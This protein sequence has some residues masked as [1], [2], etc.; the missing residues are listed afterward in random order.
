MLGFERIVKRIES[1]F[2]YWGLVDPIL[3]DDNRR[4]VALSENGEP[5]V[6]RKGKWE[7][8]NVLALGHHFS[9]Q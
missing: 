6:G 2:H 5:R 4:M 7:L 8:H 1:R 9:G 3:Q